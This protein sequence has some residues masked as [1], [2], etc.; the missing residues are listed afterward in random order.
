VIEAGRDAGGVAGAMAS[1]KPAAV[2]IR[3]WADQDLELGR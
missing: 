1:I 2:R 3:S